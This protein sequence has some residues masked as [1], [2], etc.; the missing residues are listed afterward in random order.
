LI[1]A[2]YLQPASEEEADDFFIRKAVS[3]YGFVTEREFA[4]TCKA[5]LGQPLNAPAIQARLARMLEDGQ[6]A[7][8]VREDKGE[9][10][11]Y[12]AERRGLLAEVAAGR[13]PPAWQPLGAT[14]EEEAI[15]LSPLEF[16]SARGRAW[17]VFGFDYTWEIYKPVALRKYGP[18]TLPVLYGDRLAARV[19]LRLERATHTLYV[20]GFWRKRASSRTRLFI[21]LSRKDWEISRGSWKQKELK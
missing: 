10:L 21:P 13:V 4:H 15:L 20:N 2:Q 19:D 1:P 6:L 3:Q 18:Y 11:Y 17:T 8:A 7:G 16:V 14:T 5:V 12:P 9:A